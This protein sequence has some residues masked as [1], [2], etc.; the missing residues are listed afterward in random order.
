MLLNIKDPE[1]P[2]RLEAVADSN[3]SFWHSATFNND[4]TSLI[5]TDE[6]GGGT[7]AKC[8]PTDPIDWG[9]D[10][11][12]KLDHNHLTPEGYFKMPAAQ[13]TEENC[14]AHNGGL[15]P[16]P[17][18]DILVQGWYQGGVS[19][20]DFTDPA[21]PQEIA[22]FDRGPNDST[23]LVLG[24]Y[25]CAYYYNGYIYGSEIARGLDVFK[26]RPTAY[27]TQNEIDAAN[28]VRFEQYNPQDQPKLVWPAAF[29][30][31][32]AYVDQLERDNGLGSTRI[33]GIRSTIASAEQASGTARRSTLNA[34]ATSLS[35]D[36]AN[37]SDAR[38]VR[39]L[40]DVVRKIQ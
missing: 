15:V 26:L 3:F 11:I 37:T 22:Y 28:L 31:A 30:V 18:R 33:A 6:W 35:A 39:L 7:Q 13:T 16:V 10:A 5:F 4:A 38:R 19:M 24:G 40:Q 36:L 25:W 1:H 17:G 14:V 2:V 20:Y 12:F 8:R 9:A 23:R 32:K 27:L 29:P 34:L 21:H